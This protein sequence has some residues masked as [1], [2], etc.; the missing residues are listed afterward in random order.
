MDVLVAAGTLEGRQA[1]S[2]SLAGLRWCLAVAVLQQKALTADFHR[3][4]V[5]F[6]DLW[7]GDELV[8]KLL[9]NHLLDDVL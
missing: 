2:V 3:V 9:P 4:W 1:V 7:E 6:Q 8:H 5:H